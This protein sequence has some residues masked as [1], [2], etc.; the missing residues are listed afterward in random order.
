MQTNPDQHDYDVTVVAFV[1][2]H[3]PDKI[4]TAHHSILPLGH[5][6]VLLH[7]QRSLGLESFPTPVRSHAPP[8]ND[9]A[10]TFPIDASLLCYN[11]K[12]NPQRIR[13]LY[14]NTDPKDLITA[15]QDLWIDRLSYSPGKTSVARFNIDAIYHRISSLAGASGGPLLDDK[16]NLIG[17]HNI[18][19]SQ[20]NS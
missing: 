1:D 9:A 20:L 14:P 8:H 10:T 16:G 6:C 12:P 15:I 13:D 18:S 11:G 3:D 19:N 5:D 7:S 2:G 4:R 17:K